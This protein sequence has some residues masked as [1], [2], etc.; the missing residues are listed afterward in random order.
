MLTYGELMEQSRTMSQWLVSQGLQKEE[1]VV[2]LHGRSTRLVIDLMAV[3]MAG[4]TWVP[5]SPDQPVA[6]TKRIIEVVNPR[7]VLADTDSPTFL[8]PD[9]IGPSRKERLLHHDLS[10]IPL[11]LV[12]PNQLAYILFTSGSTGKPKGVMIEH[13]SVVAMLDAFE[14]V[15][16][17]TGPFNALSVCPYVFDVSVWE[18][19]SALCYGGTLHLA[20]QNLVLD[21]DEFTTYL[22]ERSINSGYFPPGILVGL[23]K[24][25]NL[26]PSGIVLRRILVGVE[27]I[28]GETLAQFA[29]LPSKPLVVNGYGPT[30]ATI[31]ATFYPYNPAW[32]NT[33]RVPIGSALKGYEVLLLDG[34]LNAVAPGTTGEIAIGGA[35]LA[36]GYLNQPAQTKERFVSH[37]FKAGERLY[38]T[39]DLA[40]ALP[41]G[42]LVFAGRNDFQI[43]IHGHRVEPGDIETA[44]EAMPEI[45]TA[46]VVLQTD[47]TGEP[48][49]ACFYETSGK[50]ALPPDQIRNWLNGLLPP[51]MV[52]HRYRWLD[53]LPRT[54]NGKIDKPSLPGTD[55]TLKNQERPDLEGVNGT[56]AE[57]WK[58]VTGRWPEGPDDDFFVSG[59]DSLRAMHLAA[60]LSEATGTRTGVRAIFENA[61]PRLLSEFLGQKTP[62]KTTP[63]AHNLPET[64]HPFPLAFTQQRP[65]LL[66]QLG[67]DTSLYNLPLAYRIHGPVDVRRLEHTLRLIISR[68]DSLRLSFGESDGRG[69][70][71][72]HEQVP[73]A[74]VEETLPAGPHQ[75]NTLQRYLASE[76]RTPF[77]PAVAPLFRASLVQLAPDHHVLLLV[78]HHLLMDGWSLEIIHREIEEIYSAADQQRTPE[79]P[80]KSDGWLK[81]VTEQQNRFSIDDYEPGLRFFERYL[82]NAPPLLQLP[83]WKGRPAEQTFRGRSV[84]VYPN[85][86]IFNGIAGIAL[87]YNVSSY[88]VLMA[89]YGIWLQ[90]LTR[91]NDFVA[92][93]MTASRNTSSSLAATGFFS[94]SLPVRFTIPDDI[95]FG[96][97][98]LQVKE[99]LLDVTDYQDLPF[100]LLLRKLNPQRNLAY[101]PIFQ[102]MLVHQRIDKESFQLDDCQCEALHLPYPGS[103]LDLTLYVNEYE[104]RM[105]I[106]AEYNADLFQP[107]DMKLWLSGFTFFLE[108]FTNNQD[109]L[110][111][112]Y[113]LTDLPSLVKLQQWSGALAEAPSFVAVTQL[114][115]QKA[116]ANPTATALISQGRAY[117]YQWLINRSDSLASS[118]Q[119]VCPEGGG[120]ALLTART[121]EAIAAM[122]AIA[123]AGCM[124]VPLSGQLPASRL[125]YILK[126]ADIKLIVS[127]ETIMVP[128]GSSTLPVINLFADGH[129]PAPQPKPIH[130][131]TPA[132]CIYT[133]G[134]SGNPKGVVVNHGNLSNF[135]QN[136]IPG[137]GM[138]PSDRV[139]QFAALTFDASV[140]EIW[141]TWCAGATLIIRDEEMISSPERF[142]TQC[143]DLA[144]TVL[145]LPTAYF[146]HL[147]GTLAAETTRIPES[148]RLIILGGEALQPAMV[149]RWQQLAGNRPKLINTYGP[150]ETTVVTTWST[151]PDP[152]TDQPLLI[153]KPIPGS[154]VYVVDQHLRTVLPGVSGELLIG[155]KSVASGYLNQPE[156]NRHAFIQMPFAPDTTLYRSG[157][158]VK[159]HSTGELE[160]IGRIDDQLK[161]RGFRIEPAE[162]EAVVGGWPGIHDAVVGPFNDDQKG[163]ILCCWYVADEE[164]DLDELRGWIEWQLPDYM[165]PAAWVKITS[166]PLTTSGKVDRRQLPAPV[167]AP[168]E[169]SSGSWQPTNDLQKDL[170]S[171]WGSVLGSRPS[172]PDENFFL[173]GG[174]SL[175]AAS[176][177]AAVRQHL[178]VEILLRDLFANPTFSALEQRIKSQSE[179]KPRIGQ[180]IATHR[181]DGEIPLSSA[182][183]RIWLLEEIE[184][185]GP[186]FSIPLAFRI[187]GQ[188]R[189]AVLNDALQKLIT[190]KQLLKSFVLRSGDGI[191]HL[192]FTNESEYLIPVTDLSAMPPENRITDLTLRVQRNEKFKFNT[193][194]WPLFRVSLLKLAD[195]DWYLLLNFHHLI[196]DNR[197][198]GLFVDEIG[199]LYNQLLV[200]PNTIPAPERPEYTDYIHWQQEWLTGEQASMQLDRWKELLKGAPPVL[201]LP[202]DRPKPVRQSFDGDEVT[203]TLP[204]DL[205]RRLRETGASRGASLN[206]VLLT[207]FAVVLNKYTSQDDFIIGL[208][209]SGRTAEGSDKLLG[210]TINTLPI[211]LKTGDKETFANWLEHTSTVVL[212][213]MAIQDIPFERI[214]SAL[215]L[216]PDMS[217]TPLFQVMFNMLN[218]HSEE[219]RLRGCTTEYIEPT[220]HT[221]KYDLS[222]IARERGQ[223]VW[224]TF[225]YARALFDQSTIRHMGRA[226]LTIAEAVSNR[227]SMAVKQAGLLRRTDEWHPAR[228][229]HDRRNFPRIPLPVLFFDTV[230][231]YPKSI[232]ITAG[233]TDLTYTEASDRVRMIASA[234]YTVGCTTGQMVGVLVERNEWLPLALLSVLAAG[235]IYVP[236]DPVYPPSRLADIVE[237]ANIELFLVSRSTQRALPPG[238]F[239]TIQVDDPAL[240]KLPRIDAFPEIK[241][242]A[243]AYVI[244]TSGS[245]GKPKGVQISHTSLT[246]FLWSM[247]DEPGLN[248]SDKILAVT[249]VSFDIAALELFLPLIT[250]ATV[251]IASDE[252]QHDARLL[253]N[254]IA[255][256]SITLMQATPATWRMMLLS[257]WQGSPNLTILCGGEALP[258]ELMA[259]LLTRCKKLW[260][261]YGPTETTIWSTL[262]HIT[263]VDPERGF[264]QLG[265]PVANNFVYITDENLNPVPPGVLGE[266]LIG[267]EGVAKGYL[268][269]PDLTAEKF[270]SDPF[271]T[272]PGARLYKTGDL[273]KRRSDGSLEYLGRNDNQIKLRGFRI[274]PGDIEA[275]LAQHPEVEQAVVILRED[276]PSMQRLVAYL[277][278]KQP[279]TE[280]DKSLKEFLGGK[281]PDYMIPSSYFWLDDFP[282]TPNGKINRSALPAPQATHTERGSTDE[283]PKSGV[284][285]KMLNIWNEILKIEHLSVTDDFFDLGGNSLMA[286]SLMARIELKFGIRLPLATLFQHSTLRAL[287]QKIAEGEP[288]VSWR[289][290]VT[291]RPMGDKPPLFLIHG[292]GLN[293]LLYNTLV[294]HMPADQPVYALQAKGLDGKEKPLET[295]EEIAAHYIAEIRTVSPLGPFAL[296]GFSLGGII[297][298]EMARQIKQM[299]MEAFFVGMFDT[300]AYKSDRD[301]L[302][303]E[304]KRRRRRFRINQLLFAFRLLLSDSWDNRF[305]FMGLK[306]RSIRRLF[307]RMKIRIKEKKTYFTGDRDKIQQFLLPVHE[308]NNR[309]GARYVLQRAPIRIDLFKAKQQSFYIED[310]KTYGW[311][312][313]T[314][315]GVDVH[316]VP[317]EHSTIFHPPHDKQFAHT[318]QRCIDEAY[319]KFSISRRGTSE[320]T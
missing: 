115:R 217:I 305:H 268:N 171:V 198:V 182:Q 34:N 96:Q 112:Q 163:L 201:H 247:K 73:F 248:L 97:W 227:P 99:N 291:I 134:T 13:K 306:L 94:D 140:E 66:F 239:K 114:V 255:Q 149:K 24:S 297:A 271:D 241:S 80:P 30:E 109:S 144:L 279:H 307:T 95:T 177:L 260:N 238:K 278:R 174:H 156:L 313:Y 62:Q 220:G 70:Q 287:S 244:Y 69:F 51:Y 131:E 204:A 237:D 107:G 32:P 154:Q 245:T 132:Y 272:T 232:A 251:V 190:A 29:L 263:E 118:I 143:E 293:V 228:R 63:A 280:A 168:S 72:V 92:G 294:T 178:G 2:L 173:S 7:F 231:K 275:A 193:S 10:D 124:V 211:F 162:I 202:T 60:L 258:R 273:V 145:D 303:K 28:M 136:T 83:V 1:P 12:D 261:M 103:K 226:F 302:P 39:G 257:G 295:I 87:R 191:P 135:I 56:V 284:E 199:T 41:D 59:G 298:F 274:E 195:D 240:R 188:I 161:I 58:T 281:L 317:G 89:T 170:A 101:N 224:L 253:T 265:N 213:A 71:I 138:T 264:A 125:A 81:Y 110:L 180:V 189:P 203:I 126:D 225:E 311:A 216:R 146:H 44:V 230:E 197:S 205:T 289:S 254:M 120:V 17:L 312:D 184:D 74:L 42:N 122:L 160:F 142:L 133:S 262:A 207:C 200:D 6:R 61:T 57:L 316:L 214:V 141:T 179:S 54:E 27:P 108:Q 246:N 64:G 18:F 130:P 155:G 86:K 26:N 242:S 282:L 76:S 36:R 183:Q 185:L 123:T 269:R 84:F 4:G 38:L 299:G 222:L 22:S 82:K 187:R 127:D 288:T 121:P 151:I 300:V 129:V 215:N 3:V 301:L 35:G 137:Y 45:A 219:L 116:M 218:A 206:M 194:R 318:L 8:G 50:G 37:P 164:A 75:E 111:R 296:A 292:A 276:Q 25:L 308:V 152:L 104:E 235:G 139:L 11:P 176:L 147:A 209:V 102:V 47:E 14:T 233:N 314:S 285:A 23:G 68:H 153:G 159:F 19:F 33:L 77:N 212:G 48:L 266:L 169:I 221:A 46:A 277:R 15:A 157:D 223:E 259:Q 40:T 175:L 117:S 186:A 16:P 315:E 91:A 52:P 192:A 21:A 210:V 181:W 5:V 90:S 65:W 167:I 166:I 304:Q 85:T 49:L 78:T 158:L 267:G 234:L 229:R 283:A 20:A 9:W 256:H 243:T 98:V 250:G 196:A 249:T 113:R 148:L 309:A 208:P 310:P 67:G 172:H 165:V 319:G 105:S 128:E 270:L 150:T 290:L 320:P 252:E 55:G 106:M 93:T 236:L 88:T 286:V 31:C 53:R 100:E 43:K 119:A 79:L